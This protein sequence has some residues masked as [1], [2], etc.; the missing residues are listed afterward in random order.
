MSPRQNNVY[1]VALTFRMKKLF[2]GHFSFEI[3]PITCDSETVAHREE[4]GKK[5]ALGQMYTVPSTGYT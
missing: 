4:P 2:W 1:Q 3:W 5:I